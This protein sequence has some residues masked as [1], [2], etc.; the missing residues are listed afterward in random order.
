MRRRFF[1]ANL[2]G[3]NY[4]GDDSGDAR[5]G[6]ME[7]VESGEEGDGGVVLMQSERVGA[8]GRSKKSDS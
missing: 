4:L 2:R 5:R 8:I 7:E 1:I 6:R 3:V